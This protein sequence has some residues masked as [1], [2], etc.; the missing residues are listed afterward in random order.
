MTMPVLLT[1][2]LKLAS[3]GHIIHGVVPVCRFHG[4]LFFALQVNV[5]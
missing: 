1:D 3:E 4:L 2:G 5:L